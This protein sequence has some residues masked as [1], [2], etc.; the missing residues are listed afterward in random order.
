MSGRLSKNNVLAGLFV[1][2]CIGLF[3]LVVVLLTSASDPFTS[4]SRYTIRFSLEEGADGLERG[5]TV[6]LGGKRVGQVISS[7]LAFNPSDPEDVIGVDVEIEVRSDLQFYDDAHVNL[8]RPLLGTNSGLNISRLR[9]DRDAKPVE[10][11][12]MIDGQL[13]PPGFLAQEDYARVQDIIARAQKIT[14]RADNWMVEFDPRIKPM[15]DDIQQT[16]ASART[17]TEKANSSWEAWSADVTTVL[18]RFER[19]T[20]PVEAVVRSVQDGIAEVRKVVADADA[21]VT[22]N[23]PVVD[24]TLEA[25]RDLV[26][27]AQGEAY[28]R[29]IA[30]LES[31]QEGFDHAA[32]AA[33]QADELLTTKSPELKA[34]ITDATL[35]AQQLKLATMEI[36]SSPWRLLYQPNRKELENELLYNS[37][38]Q[39]SQSLAEV[40]AAAEALEAATQ[41]LAHTPEGRP[42]AISPGELQ[43]LAAKLRESLSQSSEQERRFFDRWVGGGAARP[44]ENR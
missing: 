14:E 13:G 8:V 38:R 36:R 27:K 21:W 17:L 42:A 44:A 43:S 11:G 12:A 41:N 19:A 3:V 35:A 39:Y 40:R 31:A 30:V 26:K 6:K 15:A 23:R 29:V 2:V 10:P 18:D 9:V 16:I 28:D 32:G 5:S 33:R 1:I 4:L 22:R 20:E 7:R 34:I 24:E 37:I 25:A